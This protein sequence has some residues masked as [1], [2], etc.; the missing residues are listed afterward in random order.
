MPDHSLFFVFLFHVQE[1]K[2]TCVESLGMMSTEEKETVD[3]SSEKNRTKTIM[4]EE[5]YS[6][7]GHMRGHR[8]G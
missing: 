2:I 5:D 4:G 1:N 8:D 7:G 6:L 3:N